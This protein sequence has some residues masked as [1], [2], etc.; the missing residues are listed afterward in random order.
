MKKWFVSET[1]GTIRDWVMM[2]SCAVLLVLLFLYV[3]DL[4]MWGM[5]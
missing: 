5:S 4:A 1:D 2:V 3:R